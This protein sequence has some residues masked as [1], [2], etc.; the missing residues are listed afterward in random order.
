MTG[1]LRLLAEVILRT[2]SAVKEATLRLS[3]KT[4]SNC[5]NAPSNHGG[6]RV[7]TKHDTKTWNCIG[8]RCSMFCLLLADQS[9]SVEKSCQAEVLFTGNHKI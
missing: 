1:L 3:E 4:A 2:M 6:R 7:K 8:N 5:A 9:A